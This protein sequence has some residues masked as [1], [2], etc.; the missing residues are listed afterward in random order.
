MTNHTTKMWKTPNF[1]QNEQNS[2]VSFHLK[3]CK[4]DQCEEK[5]GQEIPELCYKQ[6]GCFQPKNNL[7]TTFEYKP[8]MV[9][10]PKH[11]LE[12]FLPKSWI[13]ESPK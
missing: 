3:F 8:L 7:M 1:L 12:N 10:F 11:A 5:M 13:L 6:V 2:L 4:I 9:K